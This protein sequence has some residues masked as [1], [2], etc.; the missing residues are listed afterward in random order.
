MYP[1]N[2]YGNLVA[3]TNKKFNYG[4]KKLRRAIVNITSLVPRPFKEGEGIL[5]LSLHRCD[6]F[7]MVISHIPIVINCY[8]YSCMDGKRMNLRGYL[9]PPVFFP[10]VLWCMHEQCVP[11]PFSFTENCMK[12]NMSKMAESTRYIIIYKVSGQ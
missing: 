5:V 6:G 4:E 8:A 3:S 2:T 1:I 10:G 9:I 7:F 12:I 11:R